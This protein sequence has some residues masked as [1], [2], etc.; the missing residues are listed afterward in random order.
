MKKKKDI[1]GL[2][3][4]GVVWVGIIGS[5]IRLIMALSDEDKDAGFIAIGAIVGCL[6][7]Y[8]LIS[9]ISK[10]SESLNDIKHN[11]DVIR[12]YCEQHIQNPDNGTAIPTPTNSENKV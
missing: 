10:I 5:I 9:T 3:L 12:T 7:I 6:F 1:F 8:W 11:S 2:I 4:C